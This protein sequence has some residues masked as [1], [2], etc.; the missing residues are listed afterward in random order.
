M[1]NFYERARSAEIDGGNRY[2]PKSQNVSLVQ[3]KGGVYHGAHAY[4][5]NEFAASGIIPKYDIKLMPVCRRR[6]FRRTSRLCAAAPPDI[7]DFCAE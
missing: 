7:P 3:G 6:A 2:D 5:V 4:T 1:P